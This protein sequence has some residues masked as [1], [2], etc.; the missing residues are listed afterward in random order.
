MGKALQKAPPILAASFRRLGI[1]GF[2]F[3][4]AKGLLWLAVPW[5]AH[6]MAG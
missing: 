3:F 1:G 4:L 2:V 5:A 6:L